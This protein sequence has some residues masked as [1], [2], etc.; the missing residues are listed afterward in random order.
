MSPLI[1]DYLIPASL[2]FASLLC[3]KDINARFLIL[4]YSFVTVIDISTYD[5]ARTMPIGFYLWS[6]SMSV[7]FLVFVFGRRFWAYKF[8]T[9]KFFA[10]AYKHHRYTVQE[11]ALV[12]IALFC[13][14]NNLIAFLEVYFYSIYW[15]DE[16]LYKMNFRDTLQRIMLVLSALTCFSFA[17]KTSFNTSNLHSKEK[18]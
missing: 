6:L 8:S 11:T 7:L 12:L 15:V 17:I 4:S 10:D 3:W 14:L 5:F 2:I 13:I 9:I 1:F 18:A 16:M